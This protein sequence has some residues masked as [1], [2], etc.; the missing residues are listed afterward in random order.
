MKEKSPFKPSH[1]VGKGLMTS[2]GPVI[3]G[4]CRLLTHRDYAVEEARSFVKPA[5][6]EHYDQLET[7]D[8][9][10]SALFDLTRVRSLKFCLGKLCFALVYFSTDGHVFLGLGTCQGS[11]RSLCC[12]GGGRHSSSQS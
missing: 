10:A 2:Q 9:R 11:S 1:G 3:E 6:I 8:L 7:E 5:D 4:P 12:E